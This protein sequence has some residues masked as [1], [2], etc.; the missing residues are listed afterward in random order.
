MDIN[1]S[2]CIQFPDVMITMIAQKSRQQQAFFSL[3]FSQSSAT[4][5][6]ILVEIR[7]YVSKSSSQTGFLNLTPFTKCSSPASFYRL[8]TCLN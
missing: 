2:I 6:L 4:S 7:A 5:K 1:L 8:A 3:S